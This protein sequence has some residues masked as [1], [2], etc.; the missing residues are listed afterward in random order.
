MKFSLC[1][2]MYNEHTVIEDTVRTLSAYLTEQFG[3]DYELL[4]IDDGSTDGSAELAEALHAKN[5]RIIRYETNRGKGCA[6]RTGMLA[7]AGEIA[8]FL[9]SDLA[10]GTSVIRQGVD[11][12]EQQP[13]KDILIGS[14]VLHP[15]GYSGYLWVRKLASKAY[16]LVLNLVG[17]LKQSDSQCGCKLFRKRARQ[18]IFSN[19]QTD[20]FAF[21]FEALLLAQKLGF[22]VAEMPVKIINH[23]ESKVRLFRDAFQMLGE[24]M[25]MKRRIKRM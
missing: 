11:L 1:V 5:T 3:D 2:P 17:G 9:D 10:Y 16:I 15:E 20:G 18:E 21:D 23:R 6:V 14:R 19:M 8:M 7:A 4:L 24:L 22:S 25:R 12:L 13:E